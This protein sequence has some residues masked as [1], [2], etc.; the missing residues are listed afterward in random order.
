M[1]IPCIKCKGATPLQ[2]CGRAFCPILAKAEAMYKLENKF[3]KENFEGSSPAP[4]VGRFNYPDINVGILS[5]PEMQEEA[6]LYDAP[7]YWAQKNFEIPEIIEMRSSL[8]N[9]RFRTNI[10]QTNKFL[11]ISREIGMASKPVDLEISLDKKPAFRITQEPYLAPM[12]PNAKLKKA[13][14]ISNPKID[15]KVDKVVS[16]TDL[17]AG[18]AIAYLYRHNFDENFLSRL[19]SVGTIGIKTNRKLVPTRWSITAVDDTIAKHIISNIKQHDSTNYLSFFGG[20]LGNYFLVLLFPEVWQ[21]EL[22]ET[23]M[24]KA[25]WNPS[26]SI[27]YTTDYEPY[28][29]R[30]SYAENCG[31]G[32]YAIRLPI[33]EKLAELKKQATVLVLRFITC[34]YATHLGVWVPREAARKALSSKPIEF[35]S[36]ELMLSYTKSLVR[37]KFGYDMEIL[38]NKSIIIKNLKNQK[39]LSAFIK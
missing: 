4:F 19:L 15:Y 22:F 31:G 7:N 9:S 1:K 18:S 36:K 26:D 37:K 25:S 38:L 27:D 8:I 30:K 5:L 33:L 34:E 17:K 12:G 3:E 28:E 2:S 13:D 11:E 23:Y 29:G 16:D 35:S 10:R 24:P 6:W 32:S 20:Y 14:I 39:K 21:Y